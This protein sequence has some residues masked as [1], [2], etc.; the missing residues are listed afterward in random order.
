MIDDSL[1][2]I[3]KIHVFAKT[4]SQRFCY[5]HQAAL[6]IAQGAPKHACSGSR[7][8]RRTIVSLSAVKSQPVATID[9]LQ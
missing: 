3:E 6:F 5:T 9:A 2:W 8:Y 7:R 4:A 1:N